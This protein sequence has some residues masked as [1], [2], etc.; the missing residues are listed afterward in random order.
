M[1]ISTDRAH[2]SVP[3]D[4]IPLK[5]QLQQ[6]HAISAKLL[7]LSKLLG[8]NTVGG[9]YVKTLSHRADLNYQLLNNKFE[10]IVYYYTQKKDYVASKVFDNLKNRRKT[11]DQ[12]IPNHVLTYPKQ[13][14]LS[15]NSI[16][17]NDR[18]ALDSPDASAKTEPDEVKPESENNGTNLAGAES[19]QYVS[20]AEPNV[21]E[22]ESEENESET[23]GPIIV[24]PPSP[25]T[26]T[27]QPTP[28]DWSDLYGQN[29]Q[30]NSIINDSEVQ[31]DP[32]DFQNPFDH[33][34]FNDHEFPPFNDERKKRSVSL[35]EANNS[36]HDM[37]IL[38][39]SKR[40]LTGL[41]ISLL[42]SIGVVVYL[43]QSVHPKLAP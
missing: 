32:E 42:T 31:D 38:K 14:N 25:N 23:E 12:I 13:P 41:V 4:I 35:P 15:V 2:V 24:T 34:F 39:R 37:S 7:K 6:A 8:D 18:R 9:L 26:T 43:G 10:T 16:R 36:M 30:Q 40:F 21:D 27:S 11:I 5:S 19:D 17:F 29:V 33:E 20:D 28:I 22:T 1:V 3:I